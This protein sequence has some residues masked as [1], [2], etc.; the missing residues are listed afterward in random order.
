[1]GRKGN[2]TGCAL[3]KGTSGQFGA[4]WMI[5]FGSVAGISD[6]DLAG[7][8]DNISVAAQGAAAGC[9]ENRR[10]TLG[11]FVLGELVIVDVAL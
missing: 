6:G 7:T 9:S 2:Y 1:M 10:A 5:S 4:G 8:S 11:G 3:C